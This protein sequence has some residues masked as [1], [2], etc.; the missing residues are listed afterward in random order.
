MRPFLRTLALLASISSAAHAQA[1]A[2]PPASPRGW[3]LGTSVWMVAN[4]LPKPP[5]FYILELGRNL[6]PR[7]MLV[8]T[9][10]TWTYPGPIGIPYGESFGDPKEDYPGLVRSFG[11][12]VGYR[13]ALYR[14]L[15]ASVHAFHSAQRYEERGQP[16]RTGY[17][18]YLQARLGYRFTFGG[19]P[20]WVEPSLVGSAWP[21]Q[22]NRPASFRAKDDR[23]PSFFVAEP[24]LNVG[25]AW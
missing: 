18:L 24:W 22:T 8:V 20:L 12:A 1:D 2:P 15:G 10:L 4:A 19:V 11:L 13:R 9:A 7:D 5:H 21:I 23:W 6:T 3:S 14:G 16:A 17:Q 25:V